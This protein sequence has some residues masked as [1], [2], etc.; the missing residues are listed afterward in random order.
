MVSPSNLWRDHDASGL[1]HGELPGFAS[2]SFAVLPPQA[3]CL[4]AKFGGNACGARAPAKKTGGNRMPYDADARRQQIKA[5]LEHAEKTLSATRSSAG[6][7]S[8]AMLL[9]LERE[10]HASK[11]DLALL[12]AQLA[13]AARSACMPADETIA[14]AAAGQDTVMRQR[15]VKTAP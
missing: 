9:H 10:I 6:G 7:H 3:W 8:R 11:K 1:L 13:G 15:A 2:N 5:R 4:I 12:E 14:S